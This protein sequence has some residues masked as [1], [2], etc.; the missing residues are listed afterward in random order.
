MAYSFSNMRNVSTLTP[1]AL[2]VL[3]ISV[4]LVGQRLN[5]RWAGGGGIVAPCLAQLVGTETFIHRGEIM[6]TTADSYAKYQLCDGT[7]LYLDANTQIRLSKYPA[8]TAHQADLGITPVTELELIQGRVIVD[9]LAEVRARYAG[10]RVMGAG[11]ELVHYSWL[12]LLDVHALAQGACPVGWGAPQSLDTIVRLET[13]HG[14][15]VK[16]MQFDA[17]TSSA[18]DFYDWTGLKF[19]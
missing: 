4:F 2:I 9:G 5:A 19:E 3:V 8:L 1:A 7:M 15:V 12:D 11:C 13:Y 14:K 18:A 10:I 6:S 17:E 16:W